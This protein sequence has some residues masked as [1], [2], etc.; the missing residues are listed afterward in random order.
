MFKKIVFVGAPGVGKGTYAKLLCDKWSI[1]HV[2]VGD[3]VRREM[4]K[5]SSSKNKATMDSK[6]FDI[7]NSGGLLPDNI[8][9]SLLVEELLSLDLEKSKGHGFILDGFPRNVQQAEY[10][11]KHS[12]IDTVVHIK[13]C[14][15]IAVEKALGRK[16]CKICNHS[17]NTAHIVRDGYDMPAILPSDA[18]SLC[19]R[20]IELDNYK[21]RNS[22]EVTEIN[23]DFCISNLIT[24]SDDKE[25]T[26]KSRFRSYEL[27]TLPVMEYFKSLV[28]TDISM[29]TDVSSTIKKQTLL[30]ESNGGVR[31]EE[32]FEGRNTMD[33]SFKVHEF[34]VK[35]G[36]KD[37]DLLE[38][39]IVH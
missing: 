19:T 6:S 5:L 9:I 24:R 27:E 12:M 13:L 18:N 10:L 32:E 26:L 31:M 33:H 36:V 30:S 35:R 1:P 3:I 39:L 4:K 11:I 14:E 23:S 22:G 16:V 38:N 34:E 25:D 15:E 2:S 20:R 29:E 17:F 28:S 21:R 8:V 7:V 37:I